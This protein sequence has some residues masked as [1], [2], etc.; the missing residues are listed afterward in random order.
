VGL[1]IPSSLIEQKIFGFQLMGPEMKPFEYRSRHLLAYT[2][3]RSQFDDYLVK[4]AVKVGGEFIQECALTG[5]IQYEDYVHCQTEKGAFKGRLIVGADGTTS[6]VGKI[7]GLRTPTKVHEAGLAVEVDVPI[8][9]ALWNQVLDPSLFVI[10]LLNIP[11]GY[12]WVFPRKR[13]LSL[14]LG[15]IAG[16][17]GNLTKL[18]R[19]FS[20]MFC[21]QQGLPPFKIRN[22]RGHLLPV[23]ERVIP[24]TAHRVLLVGDAAGF[25]DA[26]S[27]Q[28]ICYALESGLIG[29]QT[30]ISIIKHHQSFSKAAFSYQTKIMQRFGEELRYSWSVMRLVHS[31]PYG[32]FRLARFCKWPGQILFDIARGKTDYYRMRRN[33]LGIICAL[34][35]SELQMRLKGW[36]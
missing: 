22:L 9:E 15:G 29:A 1:K 13:S 20:K 7:V 21:E 4:E 17:L 14:G 36:S 30:A 33:P 24:L 8:S 2:V 10:W 25:I 32:G 23:F 6:H 11:S 12:F 34:L 5:L 35:V 26:F 18:L 3:K 19:G 31:H 28:G 16:E 27:G